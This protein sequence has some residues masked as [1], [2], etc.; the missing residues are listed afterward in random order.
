[1]RAKADWKVPSSREA[2]TDNVF[3]QTLGLQRRQFSV[4]WLVDSHPGRFESKCQQHLSK[5][6]KHSEPEPQLQHW[7]IVSFCEAA[8]KMQARGRGAVTADSP[9]KLGVEVTMACRFRS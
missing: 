7:N 1:M 4:L 2:I 5:Q 6:R 8:T 9:C 3:N